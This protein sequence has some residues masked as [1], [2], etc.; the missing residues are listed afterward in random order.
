MKGVDSLLSAAFDG[1]AVVDTVLSKSDLKD[2][3]EYGYG[4]WFKFMTRYPSQ[5]LSGKKDPWYH[6]SR[7]TSNDPYDDLKFGDRVLAIF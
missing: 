6:V 7:L 3:T 4:F 5:L 2:V 1:N